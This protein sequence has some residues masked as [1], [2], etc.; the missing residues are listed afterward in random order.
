MPEPGQGCPVAERFRLAPTPDPVAVLHLAEGL[1][2]V[3]D[4][5]PE[6]AR[7]SQALDVHDH[8]GVTV[9]AAVAAAATLTDF[10]SCRT[11]LI[12]DLL[13]RCGEGE[14]EAFKAVVDIFYSPLRAAW[15]LALPADEVECAVR[16]SF[17][18]I[19]LASPR[20]RPGGET[21]VEW[22]MAHA[23]RSTAD[24]NLPGS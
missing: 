7:G 3:P 21:A 23:A 19:W 2:T 4:S 20:Y 14:V 22:I 8:A 5:A 9:L 16:G 11:G 12:S 1:V 17:A 6:T 13:L 18:A 24:D 10:S 15:A